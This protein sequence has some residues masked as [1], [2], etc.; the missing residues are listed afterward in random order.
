MKLYRVV[1]NTFSFGNRLNEQV[2]PGGEDI[3]YKMGYT[4]F[5]GKRG[6]HKYN[7]I[8]ESS[9]II[10]DGKY[11]F[12]FPEDAI[13]QGQYLLTKF[14]K[15]QNIESFYIIEYDFPIDIALQYFGYGDYKH[16]SGLPN[17]LVVIFI[18]KNQFSPEAENI[19]IPIKTIDEILLSSLTKTLENGASREQFEYENYAIMNF[20][21]S[22]EDFIS[23]P[24][25]IE[26]HLLHS[27][28][29]N[30]FHS[31]TGDIIKSPYHTGRIF[32]INLAHIFETYSS[33][34][35]ASEYFQSI[36]INC[37]LSNEQNEFKKDILIATGYNNPTEKDREQVKKLLKE[38]KYT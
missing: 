5:L 24:K 2:V 22:L 16:D 35:D 29:Y 9:N 11:F 23:N 36:G 7:N 14:H 28:L 12:L 38:R 6:F 20:Y 8:F 17:P 30:A 13:K 32:S 31:L 33:W 25:N 18:E 37:D 15:L 3:Y 27:N 19:R 10:E 4:S 1:P 34:K 21:S 26:Y